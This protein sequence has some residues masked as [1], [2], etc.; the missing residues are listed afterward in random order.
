MK[1]SSLVLSFLPL[2]A[3]SVLARFL[4]SGNIGVAGLVAALAAL[5]ALVISRPAWPPKIISAASFVLFAVFAVLGFSLGRRD[6]SWLAKWG[7]A[8]VGIILGLMI[9]MLLP[10]MPFTEQFAREQV[11]RSAWGSPTFRR[12]NLVLSAAWGAAITLLG[13]SRLI[14]AALH[15]HHAIEVIFGLVLPV[16]ILVRMVG[17]SRTY[18]DRVRR[19]SAAA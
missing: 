10:V 1:T 14:A 15:E 13:C 6:D 2:V 16:L 18:P 8:G 12:V 9:L 4:P 19:D 11:P 5:L 3:F 7:G 17:F